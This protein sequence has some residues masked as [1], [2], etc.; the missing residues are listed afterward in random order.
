ET[1]DKG[2]FFNLVDEKNLT[3]AEQEE[4]EIGA[5]ILQLCDQ[6]KNGYFETMSAFLNEIKKILEQTKK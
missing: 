2:Q 4:D 3:P 6:Y 5:Q 1:I